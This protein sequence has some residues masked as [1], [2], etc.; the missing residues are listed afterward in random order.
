MSDIVRTFIL[1]NHKL[2]AITKR[3][4]IH[5]NLF[6]QQPLWLEIVGLTEAF[7]GALVS[8]GS[9]EMESNCKNFYQ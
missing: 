3:F 6:P 8:D 5:M 2:K 1:S 7:D 4:K 9:L